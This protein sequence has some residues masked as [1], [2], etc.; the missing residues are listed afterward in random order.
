ME[1]M[2]FKQAQLRNRKS[3][4]IWRSFGFFFQ[5]GE[6]VKTKITV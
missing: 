2:Q 3:E 5:P 4:N 1:Y 6:K